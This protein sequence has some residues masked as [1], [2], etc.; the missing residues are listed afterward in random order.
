[1]GTDGEGGRVEPSGMLGVVSI[2][3]WEVIIQGD[4]CVD[5]K[6][7]T[8]DLYTSLYRMSGLYKSLLPA[9]PYSLGGLH[10]AQGGLSPLT[11]ARCPLHPLTH[12][13]MVVRLRPSQS[14]TLKVRKQD[15]GMK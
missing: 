1:M 11:G 8:E 6:Q 5:L 2:L 12:M 3:T 15:T 9:S 4:V 13:V 10:G 14:K 7:Y